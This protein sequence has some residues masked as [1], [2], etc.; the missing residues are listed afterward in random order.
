MNEISCG[1]AAAFCSKEKSEQEGKVSSVRLHLYIA[2]NVNLI[3]GMNVQRDYV[4][5]IQEVANTIK[6]TFSLL[7]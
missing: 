4:L 5:K 2:V 6:K 3:V 7:N 1:S